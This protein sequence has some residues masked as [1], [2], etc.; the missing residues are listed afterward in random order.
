[1]KN[2]I[3]A[4]TF[5]AALGGVA[6]AEPVFG[7]AGN[8]GHSELS[9]GFPLE[10]DGNPNTHNFN[11][12]RTANILPESSKLWQKPPL[13]GALEEIFGDTS[14]GWALRPDELTWKVTLQ[15]GEMVDC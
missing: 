2:M 15:G 4:I 7:I 12:P 6:H 10:V 13:V 8:F 1:M 5:A 14:C 11:Q 9:Y 3:I